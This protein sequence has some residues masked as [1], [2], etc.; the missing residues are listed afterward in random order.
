MF[1]TPIIMITLVL[2]ASVQAHAALQAEPSRFDEQPV[3]P[4]AVLERTFTLRNH[5][6]TA[7]DLDLEV[8]TF[9]GEEVSI[10]PPRLRL[11]PGQ[12]SDVMVTIR[13]A[14]DASG[15]RHDIRLTASGDATDQG[16]LATRTAVRLP[17]IVPVE[18]LKTASL[19]ISEADGKWQAK[20]MVFNH[21]P[22]RAEAALNVV[23]RDADGQEVWTSRSQPESIPVD[24]HRF[25]SVPLPEL[26]G[27]L[28]EVEAWADHGSSTSNRMTQPLAVGTRS[29]HV[30]EVT[31]HHEAGIYRLEAPFRNDGTVPL[32]VETAFHVTDPDGTT[33]VS[34][35]RFELD[36]GEE[37]TAAVQVDLGPGTHRIVAHAEWG[38]GSAAS[39][40]TSYAP[41]REEDSGR[42][43]PGSAGLGILA[44]AAAGS[45][46]VVAAAGFAIGKRRRSDR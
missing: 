7:V 10:A 11:E 40:P 22:E 29:V 36:P 37:E 42:G 20:A 25:L 15:G 1:R 9:E 38:Q 3:A 4:G 46:I 8:T 26:A 17:V 39:E 5:A 23:V 32:G 44:V 41:T 21:L 2:A 12:A 33:V 14:S 27:G 35:Q 30:G 45:A 16:D 13:F 24:R 43:I 31:V 6:D 28:Y 18:N 34:G 19:G